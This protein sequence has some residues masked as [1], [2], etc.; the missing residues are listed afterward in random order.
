MSWPSF[1]GC[2]YSEAD[3]QPSEMIWDRGIE[4]CER[5]YCIIVHTV[6]DQTRHTCSPGLMITILPYPVRVGTLAKDQYH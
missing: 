2:M 6:P 1:I 5:Y 3:G 4:F